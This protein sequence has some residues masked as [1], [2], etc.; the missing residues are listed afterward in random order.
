MEPEANIRQGKQPYGIK[1]PENKIYDGTEDKLNFMKSARERISND[2]EFYD[3]NDPSNN[4]MEG[5]KKNKGKRPE[6]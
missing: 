4:T 3:P 2:P 1:F 6:E 5:I